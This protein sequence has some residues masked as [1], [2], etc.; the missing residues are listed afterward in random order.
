MLLPSRPNRLKPLWKLRRSRQ[1]LIGVCG[2]SPTLAPIEPSLRWGTRFD[3][4]GRRW[5]RLASSSRV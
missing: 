1:L 4:W 5:A 3:G 2:A